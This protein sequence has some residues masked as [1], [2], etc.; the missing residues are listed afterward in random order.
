MKVSIVRMTIGELQRLPDDGNRYEL[1]DGELYV[2]PAPRMKHQRIS[3]DLHDWLSPFAKKHKL[4]QVY[5][6][7]CDVFAEPEA[8]TCVQPDLLF[9]SQ[10]RLYIVREEGVFGPPDLVVE[11]VSESTYKADTTDKRDLYRR[12]GVAEYWI[13]NPEQRSILVYRF[14]ES[15][16]PR[17]LTAG[18]TLSTPLLPGLEIPL[19]SLFVE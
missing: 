15:P 8:Q 6:A 14:A 10:D 19:S 18:E 9:I 12:S 2:S 4:G 7:P 11:I 13:V 17:T 3:S 16:E 5:H 1:I